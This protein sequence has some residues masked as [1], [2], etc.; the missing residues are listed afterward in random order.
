[1]WGL[2]AFCNVVL[3]SLLGYPVVA[4]PPHN[5]VEEVSM[6]WTKGLVRLD[7]EQ[8]SR[9]AAGQ[10]GARGQ[11]A[12]KCGFTSQYDGLPLWEA[13]QEEGLVIWVFHATVRLSGKSGQLQKIA[14]FCCVNY[15]V[16]F[17]LLEKQNVNGSNRSKLYD[18]LVDSEVG[19]GKN[20]RWNF[21]KFV[22][23]R[24]GKV[25]GR[26]G[27]MTKPVRRHSPRYWTRR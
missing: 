23:D 27:S 25:V 10:S 7:G 20:I 1:M 21:E 26:F 24:T 9:Y 22:V 8:L 3:G 17:P 15:G 5:N 19:A 13:R 16:D 4:A 11:C 6:E 14:S 18:Y 12:S 2:Y